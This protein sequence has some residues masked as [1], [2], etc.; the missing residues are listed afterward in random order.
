MERISQNIEAPLRV[1]NRALAPNRAARL[2]RLIAV[3]VMGVALAGSLFINNGIGLA[4]E[5]NQSARPTVDA[6]YTT[7]GDSGQQENWADLVSGAPGIAGQEKWRPGSL[8]MD[9]FVR[10]GTEV[11]APFAGTISTVGTTGVIITADSG[12]AVRFVHVSRI[13]PIPPISPIHGD[14]VELGQVVA[15]VNDPILDTLHW[16]G[17]QYGIAPD[18]FQHLDIS[19]ATNRSRLSMIP[20]D[21]GDVP[22]YPYTRIR[23]G[24]R[25]IVIIPRTPGPPEGTRFMKWAENLFLQMPSLYNFLPL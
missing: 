8:G 17:G 7:I 23:G 25:N 9:V 4:S 1:E 15:T 19:T 2:R 12:W 6:A 21:G 20:G 24:I 10:R 11:K 16:P 18:G 22:T 14:R 3:G 13:A 5:T